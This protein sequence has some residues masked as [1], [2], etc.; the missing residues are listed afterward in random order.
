MLIYLALLE[1][2]APLGG[3]HDVFIKDAISECIASCK[4][5]IRHAFHFFWCTDTKKYFF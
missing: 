5:R 4:G 1:H 2:T 3:I